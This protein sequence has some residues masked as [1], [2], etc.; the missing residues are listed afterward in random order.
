[1]KNRNIQF[2]PTT[3]LLIPLLLACFAAVFASAAAPAIAGDTVPF[4]GIVSGTI[5]SSVP[6]D[7]CHTLSA[8]RRLR[9]PR[10]RRAASPARPTH[11]HCCR[12]HHCV[13]QKHPS[14]RSNR[15]G[16]SA[17]P[18][19]TPRNRTRKHMVGV[20]VHTQLA[21]GAFRGAYD[22]AFTEAV[23]AEV[24]RRADAVLSSGR[25]VVIDASFRS[26]RKCAPPPERSPRLAGFHFDS[27]S[28]A[29]PQEV[30]RARLVA[31]AASPGVSDG[32]LAIF[33]D[34]CARFEPVVEILARE[35]VVLDTER[36]IEEALRTLGARV[37]HFPRGLVD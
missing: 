25:P 28:A 22:P 6:L 17:L 2:K 14:G 1:M 32:R 26:V 37:P 12:R 9:A 29:L 20:S 27:S 36:P 21:E 24:R 15:D 30:C 34:F 16:R 7:E 10:P 13:R 19:S 8:A 3:G 11:A 18:S 31:R 4:N 33:D 5:I 23:Y 35:H